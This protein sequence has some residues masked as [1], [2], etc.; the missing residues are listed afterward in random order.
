M[1]KDLTTTDS[2]MAIVASSAETLLAQAIEKGSGIDT[3]ERLMALRKEMLAEQA[4]QK[5]NEAMAAFQSE[6]P[7]IEKTKG[8]K[9]KSGAT[10]YKYAPIESIVEQVK[11]LLKKHGFRYMVTMEFDGTRVKAICRVVHEA[12]HEE[13][14]SFDVP[15]GTK[16]E[17][18]S[19]TQVV[20]AA[21]TFAKRYAFLNAFGIMTGD[22]D[23]DAAPPRPVAPRETP[24]APYASTTLVAEIIQLSGET[25][26]D[27]KALVEHYKAQAGWTDVSA[28]SA[29][30]SLKKKL[31]KQI[32]DAEK[33]AKDSGLGS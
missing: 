20:A 17:I 25:E 15:L 28:K 5:F 23:N 13:L 31:A 1:T 32:D 18:M 4:K 2:S 7:V 11:E 10:A 29:I 26:T 19:Q 33:K 16:T 12:G 8:V 21:S 22:E 24:K 9:T 30:A 6:C 14:S 3:L 27:Y